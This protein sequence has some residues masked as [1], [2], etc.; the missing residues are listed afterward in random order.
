MKKQSI[1]VIVALALMATSATA[2]NK[3][4]KEIEKD[5]DS[6]TKIESGNVEK[7]IKKEDGVTTVKTTVNGVKTKTVLA[8]GF[9]V[10]PSGLEYKF[11]K[12]APGKPAELSDQ[13]EMHFKSSVGDSVMFD[14]RV[15][16]KGEPV[17]FPLQK[18]TWN[19]DVNEGLAM[20]S[21]GD[22]A[23]F[24]TP[25]DSV[26]KAGNQLLPWMKNSDKMVYNVEVLTIKNQEQVKKDF[27]AKQAAQIS[28]DEKILQDYFK[29]KN[30]KPTKTASGLYYL[31]TKP[32][33]GENAK[34]GQQVTVNYTGKTTNGETFDSNVD[35]AF[36]HVQPFNFAL[37]KGQVIKGWDE[38][39][40]LMNKGAK[41]TLFIPSRYAY[42]PQSPSPKI[43]ANSVLI[44]DV[45]VT[46]IAAGAA[47]APAGG[48]HE[49]HDHGSHDGHQ[50]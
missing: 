42:G 45:E 6:K 29:A 8:D 41:A 39:V 3:I 14:S 9:S 28:V 43:P 5:G 26:A 21:A 15:M 12:D 10:L 49:G 30:V 33:T 17:L 11:V 2:Q 47:P 35:P 22:I 37:G 13:M 16:M 18:P 27:E 23:V 20:L 48:G 44:F 7:K 40:A 46:D 19:G 25:L 36:N 38:G 24:R 31:I 32:G 1:T 34:A 50:H 4:K